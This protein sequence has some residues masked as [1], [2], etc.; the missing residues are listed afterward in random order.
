M[1]KILIVDDEPDYLSLLQRRL[2]GVGYAVV[3][4]ESGTNI[5]MDARNT[6]PDLIILDINIPGINGF[7]AYGMLHR[8][9]GLSHIPIIFSSADA[10]NYEF[11]QKNEYPNTLFLMKPFENEEI[12]EAIAKLVTK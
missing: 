10:A 12:R 3:T 5:L 9:S 11:F 6:K 7:E 1:K 8:D 4:A 2:S